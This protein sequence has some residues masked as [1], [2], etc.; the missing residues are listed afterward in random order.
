M[1]PLPAT[2]IAPLIA[3]VTFV[4]TNAA[5][6]EYSAVQ[7]DK[8]SLTFIGKQMGVAVAGSFPKFTAQL[9][10]DPARPET[11]KVSISIDL[12]SMPT[13]KSLARTGSTRARFRR[14]RLSRRA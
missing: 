11:G 8:S 3:Y 5:A 4:S 6:I 13:M 7:A 1:K 2:L 10:F 12:A 9:A 14:R